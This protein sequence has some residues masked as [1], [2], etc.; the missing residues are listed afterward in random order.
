MKRTALTHNR[1]LAQFYLRVTYIVS[2]I[3]ML[4][5]SLLYNNKKV[6]SMQLQKEL[7]D[8]T[9]MLNI[10][11]VCLHNMRKVTNFIVLIDLKS[12]SLFSIYLIIM[13]DITRILHIY[14]GNLR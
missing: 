11:K 5:T 6:N 4:T 7:D 12:S 1:S 3:N 10:Y 9:S 14:F 13:N 2:V 8:S